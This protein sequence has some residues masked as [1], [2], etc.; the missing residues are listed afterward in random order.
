MQGFDEQMTNGKED[1]IFPE[2]FI[3][4]DLT[5]AEELELEFI[6]KKAKKEKK[7]CVSGCIIVSKKEIE[8]QINLIE[9][10]LKKIDNAVEE[11]YGPKL[12]PNVLFSLTEKYGRKST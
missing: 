4:L 3:T 12:D 6:L 1:K 2:A 7:E 9:S 5:R 8:S 11:I 10:V